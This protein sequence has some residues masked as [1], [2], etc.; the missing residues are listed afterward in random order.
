M[1]KRWIG[2][3]L[4]LFALLWAKLPGPQTQRESKPSSKFRVGRRGGIVEISTKA[5]ELPLLSDEITG[6]TVQEVKPLASGRYTADREPLR[7]DVKVQITKPN[8]AELHGLNPNMEDLLLRGSGRIA[9]V[10]G[11]VEEERFYKQ[12]EIHAQGKGQGVWEILE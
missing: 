9:I 11:I 8:T 5:V 6:I 2:Y 4:A 1:R 7:S 10:T 3:L 12:K